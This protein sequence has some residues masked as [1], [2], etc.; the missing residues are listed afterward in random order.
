MTKLK[1]GIDLAVMHH[2]GQVRK[3]SLGGTFI[4]YIVHPIAVMEMVWKWGVGRTDIL[5][6]AVCHDLLEDTGCTVD[7]LFSFIGSQACGFVQDLTFMPPK[8][9]SPEKKKKLKADFMS[10]FKN[11]PIEVLIV[12]MADRFRNT[13]DFKLTDPNYA[14]IY[15]EKA[16]PLFKAFETRR[17]EIVDMFGKDVEEK[18]VRTYEQ[19]K[20]VVMSDE[21]EFVLVA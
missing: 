15:F 13:L 12:K 19:M 7:E 8:S 9:A 5:L 17:S 2:K 1:V 6:A 10:T 20:K 18:V 21:A 14:R 11:K 4:P 16:A 3:T